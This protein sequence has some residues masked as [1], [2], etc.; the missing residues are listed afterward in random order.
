[1]PNNYFNKLFGTSSGQQPYK[2]TTAGSTN[3]TAVVPG[4]ITQYPGINTNYNPYIWTTTSGY[5]PGLSWKELFVIL[6][7]IDN[8]NITNAF[9]SKIINSFAN[10]L[11]LT[12]SEAE[13]LLTMILTPSNQDNRENEKRE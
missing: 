11:G 2:I 9:K 6:K 3:Q 5:I 7:E 12:A 10:N 1:M 4:G 8:P 13:E